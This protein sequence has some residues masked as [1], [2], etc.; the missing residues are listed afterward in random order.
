[1]LASRLSFVIL[2]L[3]VILIAAIFLFTGLASV[4]Y[5]AWSEAQGVGDLRPYALV[6]FL[7]MLLIPVLLLTHRPLIGSGK[8]YMTPA[9]CLYAL[10]LRR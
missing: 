1:L 6:Q 3:V 9:A 5:W 4:A 10:T 2:V 7:P 8:H